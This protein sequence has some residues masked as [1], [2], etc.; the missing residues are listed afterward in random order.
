MTRLG[1][2]TCPDG[3]PKR[4]SHRFAPGCPQ[5]KARRREAMARC[6][7][8]IRTVREDADLPTRSVL[9]DY[10]L[11]RDASGEVVVRP[12]KEGVPEFTEVWL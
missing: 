5:C 7:A 1:W 11:T 8:G 12:R 4:K 2:N 10:V 3:A 9:G 6:R